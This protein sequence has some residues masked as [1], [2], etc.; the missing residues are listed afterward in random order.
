MQLTPTRFDKE[1]DLFITKSPYQ[2]EEV[3]GNELRDNE[4]PEVS[5]TQG[6][7]LQPLNMPKLHPQELDK[8]VTEPVL[9]QELQ[10]VWN[11]TVDPYNIPLA[12]RR[13]R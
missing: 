11:T 6:I 2:L 1:N 7:A 8:A 5:S 13:A 9:S 12:L 3:N 4:W 10:E